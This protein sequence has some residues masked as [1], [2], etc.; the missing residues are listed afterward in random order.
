MNLS[1]RIEGLAPCLSLLA[2][3]T[4]GTRH[5]SNPPP[6]TES[7]GPDKV[8][9]TPLKPSIPGQFRTGVHAC[10]NP[11]AVSAT[12]V[13]GT[14]PLV[15]CPG[16]AGLRP[17]PSV[18]IRVGALVTIA[19]LP[20]KATLTEEPGTLTRVVQRTTLIAV[21]PGRSVITVHNCF[22]APRRRGLQP[23]SCTLLTIVAS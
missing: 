1:R 9:V 2:A 16:E 15:D 19:G 21:R 11:Y 22:C 20:A 3:C 6:P 14:I 8:V 13:R 7:T 12:T 4:S 23:K 17:T 5:H 10:G 18:T